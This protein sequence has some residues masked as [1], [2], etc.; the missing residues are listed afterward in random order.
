M[1]K[2]ERDNPARWI[3]SK[4]G[5]FLYVKTYN[6]GESYLR[7]IARIHIQK[8]FVNTFQSFACYFQYMHPNGNSAFQLYSVLMCVIPIL[9]IFLIGSISILLIT[10]YVQNSV[11]GKKKA[12]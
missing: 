4:F 2:Y 5:T 9:Y 3:C 11:T 12:K 10:Y 8:V 1:I 7:N 6:L